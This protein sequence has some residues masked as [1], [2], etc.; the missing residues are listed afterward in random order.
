MNDDTLTQDALVFKEANKDV[1]DLVASAFTKRIRDYD[2]PNSINVPTNLRTYDGTT[3][4]ADHLTVFMGTWTYTNFPSRHGVEFSKSRYQGQPA[5]ARRE[6]G[7]TT[8]DGPLVGFAGQISWPLGLITLP[9]TVK[10][11]RSHVSKTI[12]AE[13]MI[14]RAPSPYNIILGWQGMMKL[15]AVASTLHALLKFETQGG[16]A[17]VRGLNKACPKD[18][19]PLPEID[20]KIESLEGFK[21]KCILDT[22][23]GYHQIRMGQEDEEKTSFHTEQGI[24]CYEKMSFELKN[25]EATYQRLMDNMFTSQLG[26]NIEIYVDDM[27]IKSKNEGNLIS[28]I[29]EIFDT[30]CK[31]NM[32]LNPKKCT[33]GVE[34]RQFLR[35][36][37]TN[38]GIQA[39]PKKVQ[40]IINMASPRTLCEELKSHLQSLPALTIPRPKETLVLYLAAPTEAIR[41]VLLTNKGNVQRSIYFMSRA[42]QGLEINYPSLEKVALTLVHTA[43][44]LCRYFQAHT[45]CVLIDQP[46]RQVLLKP[47]NSRHLAKWAIEL[48]EH[49][50]I[51]KPCSAIKGQVIADFLAE[52][53]TNNNATVE[54]VPHAYGKDK[55]SRWTLFT[56]GASRIEGSGAGLIL[57][58]PG[59]REIT[60]ALRSTLELPTKKLN[61]KPSW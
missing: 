19:Y 3:N 27:V 32:K 9:V 48:D 30:L 59:G 13:F 43:R 40:A 41:A 14:I 1:R 34:I 36:M 10:D 2:M 38:E 49:K 24:F 18:I 55:T 17:I 4:P 45:I 6:K 21:L 25:A 11:Y 15:R 12:I 22:Y 54:K 50:I 52:P 46:I 37:I 57:T 60:Y 8:S 29:A 51:Y 53:S 44:R 33:F 28:D 39:N 26:R 61:T 16:V 5:D 31:A 35:Y 23:K 42:L 58:N 56:D 7:N 20:H 47:K